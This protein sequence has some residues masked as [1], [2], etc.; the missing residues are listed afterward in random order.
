MQ[1]VARL[2]TQHMYA[3]IW[4]ASFGATGF[5]FEARAVDSAEDNARAGADVDTIGPGRTATY[6]QFTAVD[7]WHP[8][9]TAPYSGANSLDP[10]PGSKETMDL[11]LFAGVRTWAG[12]E[13]WI[14]PEI[15]QGFGLSNTVGVAG[16]PNGEAYKIGANA[17]YIRI[18]R[19][20]FR[21]VIS[22]GGADEKVE[23]GSNQ[24]SGT[25]TSD[26]VT[27]TIGKL[28]VPDIFDV[29]TYAHDPRSDFLNWSIIEAGAFDYAADSWAYTYGAAAEW[30]VSR[31]TLR[32]GVFDLSKVP[33]SKQQDPHFR[34]YEE[35]V[36][37]EERH[38][39]QGHDGKFK[40][41][42]YLNRGRMANYED[43]V[44]L[45]AGTGNPPDTSKARRYSSRPGGAINF[46]QE[47]TADLGIFARASLNDGRKEAFEF[48]EI[49]KS[50]SGGVSLRGDRWGRHED[51]VGVAA[52]ANGLSP[53]ARDYFS[54]GGLGILIGDGQLNFGFEKIAETYYS[55]R[56]SPH[57][58]LS[59]DYQYV[60][61]PA[62]NRDRGPVSIFG[63]RLHAEF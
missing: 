55:M 16:F 61:N 2:M 41:L 22:I 14:N 52:A 6:W 8:R 23:P 21:Q 36:E 27:L 3:V 18:P 37:L 4:F 54:A 38:Q 28:S 42:G 12:G 7:Q 19:A 44:H 45:A 11:T 35:V 9:F 51:S 15:D 49:N 48:T 50:V 40:I 56:V 20:F 53:Q 60:V 24:M 46:E 26:N 62:Y 59:A 1:F 33:N 57:L 39:W 17:P 25:R 32:G 34:Q 31:W 10:A 63:L 13:A 29:N 43:A 30:N 58:K 5:A 47:I